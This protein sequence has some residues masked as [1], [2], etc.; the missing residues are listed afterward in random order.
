MRI[1]PNPAAL[2]A[3]V[4]GPTRSLCSGLFNW[5]DKA[6]GANKLAKSALSILKSPKNEVVY[7]K[8]AKSALSILKSPKNEVVYI[9]LA[10][11][12]L[13]ILKSPKNDV[14]YIKLNRK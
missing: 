13:S 9:K 4:N 3:A 10:K 5:A 7:I 11:S 6:H 14:V 2:T 8:L 1:P 12:A